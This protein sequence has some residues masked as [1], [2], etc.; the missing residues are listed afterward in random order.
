MILKNLQSIKPK[1]RLIVNIKKIL[2]DKEIS[3]FNFKILK[4]NKK[5]RKIYLSWL[6]DREIIK[7]IFSYELENTNLNELF[8]KKSI[9]RFSSKKTIGFFIFLKNK[10]KFVGTCK[11]DKIDFLKKKAHIGIMIGEKSLFGNGI[12]KRVYK[13]LIS[14]SKNILKLR[15]IYSDCSALNIPMIK[16]LKKKKF[17]LYKKNKCTDSFEGNLYDHLYYR[18]NL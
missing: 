3:L 13:I 14:Y 12:G 2:S 1:L 17:K 7:Y 9:K 16:I 18:L 6:K 4:F 15:Y 8:I 11:L 5:L 10:R